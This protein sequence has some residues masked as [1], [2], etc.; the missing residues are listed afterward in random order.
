MARTILVS[1]RLPITVKADHDVLTVLRS[2]GGLAAG[3]KGPHQNSG[4]LWVG[5]PGDVSRLGREQVAALER[6]LRDLRLVPIYLTPSEVGHY[7]EGFSNGVLWP[8]FHYLL[9]RMK[10]DSRGA[11]WE[12]YKSINRR[13]AELIAAHHQPGD[14]IWVH[15]YQLCLV[16]A[17]LRQL[18]PTAKIGF[19]L[20]IPFPASEVFRI[21]PCRA[22]ILEGILGADLIG[23]HTF[24]YLRNFSTSLLRL[25]G[26][27]A[28]IDRVPV[29]GRDVRLGVFPIGVDAPA[30]EALAN[31][32]EVQ[33]EAATIQ[34]SADGRKLIL[35]I[36]RLDYTK[37]MPRRLLAM[38][39]FL[40][41]EP[42][43]RGRIRY[44]QVAV[45][46][47]EKI[48]AYE[49]LRQQV[50]DI[51][52]R[53]NGLYG[54]ATDV[55]IHYLY[56]GFN[57]RQVAAFYRSA[58]VMLVNPLRDGM[59]LVAKEFVACRSDEDGVLI[60]SEFA[61]AAVQLDQALRI[62][63]Y[64]I[65]ATAE[66]IKKALTMPREERRSRMKALRARVAHDDIHHWARSFLDAL[67]E[68]QV[69]AH[70]PRRL[71]PEIRQSLLERIRPFETLVLLLDYDGTLVPFAATPERAVPDD[72]LRAL[73]LALSQ[74]PKTEV[75]IISGR[76][77]DTLDKWFSG[78]PIGLHAEHG[79]W[80]RPK[81]GDE[82]RALVEI[83]P[84]WKERVLPIIEH[85][86]RRTPG[87]LIEHKSA[88][89]AWHYRTADP[90]FGALQ[91]KELRLH[92]AEVL[93]NFP[94]HVL[95]GEKVVEVKVQGVHKGQIVHRFFSDK[96]EAILVAIGDDRTDEDL[97]A[98]L[99][100]DG[101]ALHVGPNPSRAPYRLDDY[102]DVRAFLGCLLAPGQ[103]GE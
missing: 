47:R 40:E 62:N 60:L 16:P 64:D 10:L 42:T 88:S 71:S 97:F 19:F 39:R 87:S 9:D 43:W 66:A 3:L 98:M 85:F 93:S 63:P 75:H 27:D 7:Y 77:R 25:L 99:P 59:N 92:L 79:L 81:P 15:D 37:G 54:T 52:S 13:F 30:F 65:E 24:S 44:V 67:D 94:V 80:S 86:T 82:W 23:F 14:L 11:D 33:A 45:P 1:N 4:G 21:L 57:E 53:I 91:A 49:Q 17:L 36:D 12:S 18:I 84:H 69:A 103:N 46:S 56:R 22:A 78:L 51:V 76:D 48:A 5:W 6:Q 70:A 41:R 68:S 74:R 32:P 96:S 89:I 101:I 90:E 73:L 8:L 38:E 35:G 100:R 50:H 83:P 95:P 61:G 72:E 28:D 102:R 31:S 20:H 34:R 58:D 26:I 29:G 55:P 2:P